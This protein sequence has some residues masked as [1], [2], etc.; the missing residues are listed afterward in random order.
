MRFLALKIIKKDESSEQFAPSPEVDKVWHLHLIFP[1][2]YQQDVLAYAK[3]FKGKEFVVPHCPFLNE[4]S[5]DRY[6]ATF[7]QIKDAKL[8]KIVGRKVDMSFWPSVEE[9]FPKEENGCGGCC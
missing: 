5:K 9:A 7:K 3:E 6:E 8:A 1:E 4:E 2:Q